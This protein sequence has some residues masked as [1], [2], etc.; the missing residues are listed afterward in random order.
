MCNDFIFQF[1][2]CKKNAN[3]CK[4]FKC[5]FCQYVG[6]FE[7]IM[8]YRSV[9]LSVFFFDALWNLLRWINWSAFYSFAIF[10]FFDSFW[11]FFKG[12]QVQGSSFCTQEEVLQFSQ[13]FPTVF[14]IDSRSTVHLSS[15]I[16]QHFINKVGK[17]NTV[18][19]SICPVATTI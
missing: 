9:S 11:H 1:K 13:Y 14:F 17:M 4:Q 19:S 12:T 6:N 7:P 15:H 2:Y 5:I 10:C 8:L 3:Y 18:I 16:R